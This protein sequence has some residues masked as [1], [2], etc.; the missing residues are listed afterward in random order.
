MR[1]IFPHLDDSGSLDTGRSPR[2]TR[3]T[4]FPA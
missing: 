3:T 2:A 4:N 1:I